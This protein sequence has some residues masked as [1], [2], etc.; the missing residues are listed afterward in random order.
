MVVQE[1]TVPRTG[2]KVFTIDGEGPLKAAKDFLT[3]LQCMQL[4]HRAV[5]NQWSSNRANTWLETIWNII[6]IIANGN[7]HALV[8]E[9]LEQKHNNQSILSQCSSFQK[10]RNVFHRLRWACNEWGVD[11]YRALQF[12]VGIFGETELR[13]DGWDC[14]QTSIRTATKIVKK[15]RNHP[16]IEKPKRTVRLQ[17]QRVQYAS[18]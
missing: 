10:Y 12:V 2:K 16:V 18:K 11:K 7:P 13:N 17:M 3:V 9:F 1:L 14:S 15:N 5:R 8:Q 4:D 6:K